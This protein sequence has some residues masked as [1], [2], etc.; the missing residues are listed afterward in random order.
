METGGGAPKLSPG[1]QIARPVTLT[2]HVAFAH[3]HARQPPS[4]AR[5]QAPRLAAPTRTPPSMVVSSATIWQSGGK[6]AAVTSS[7]NAGASIIVAAAAAGWLAGGGGGW[8]AG[9]GGRARCMHDAFLVD[10]RASEHLYDT[11]L[12]YIPAHGALIGVSPMTL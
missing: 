3:A 7:V 12:W 9:G 2:L 1:D 6:L 8:L 5:Q 10:L 11:L 4:Q